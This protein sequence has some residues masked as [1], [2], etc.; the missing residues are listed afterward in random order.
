MNQRGLASTTRRPASRPSTT[1]APLLCAL[2]R[3]P[4]RAASSSATRKPMLCRLP[5]YR[6]PGLP[7]PTTRIGSPASTRAQLLLHSSNRGRRRR[8]GTPGAARG[9]GEPGVEH[10]ARGH[11]GLAVQGRGGPH[12]GTPPPRP[13][14]SR[15]RPS[16]AARPAGRRR[17]AA[18]S[19]PPRPVLSCRRTRSR[20]AS[21][22]RGP[23]RPR[24]RARLSICSAVGASFTAATRASA[25]VASDAPSGSRIWPRSTGA[26]LHAREGQLDVLGDVQRVDL[27]LHGRQLLDDQGAG[28]A[29]PTSTTG[30]STVIFSPRCTSSRSTCSM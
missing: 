16:A 1:S 20:N 5:A 13:D 21:T 17:S 6:G 4:T 28:A 15:A 14:R 23:R 22:S 19:R 9:P 7:S 3:P 8:P 26:G 11:R 29:S 18:A 24:C 25:S 27:D 2:N 10:L 12:R 30:T